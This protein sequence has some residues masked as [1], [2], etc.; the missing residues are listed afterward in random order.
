MAELLKVSIIICVISV[1]FGVQEGPQSEASA[2]QDL[3]A[4]HCRMCVVPDRL[5]VILVGDNAML[6]RV[7]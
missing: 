1:S 3:H 6:A 2:P 7:L 5:H 4:V